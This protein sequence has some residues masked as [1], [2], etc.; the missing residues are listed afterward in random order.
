MRI[1]TIVIILI[2]VLLTTAIVQNNQTVD[3]FFLWATFP[4]S[5]LLMLLIVAIISFILGLLVAR[6]K[7]AIR[8][9][10]G[11]SA[12][13]SAKPNPNTLSDEDKDYIN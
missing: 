1:K 6:P 4:M 9:G 7:K 13:D 5:K 2:T 8:L 10:D 3:F 11:V 12:T